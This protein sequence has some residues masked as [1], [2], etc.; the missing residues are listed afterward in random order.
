MLCDPAFDVGDIGDR[1]IIADELRLLTQPR[2]EDLATTP[3][4]FR[5]AIVVREERIIGPPTR[6]KSVISFA[7]SFCFSENI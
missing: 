7:V 5:Y 1:N 3:V 6:V 4:V 2:F